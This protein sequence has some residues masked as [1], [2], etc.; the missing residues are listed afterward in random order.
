MM[1]DGNNR[2]IA[3]RI[4]SWI[5]RTVKQGPEKMTGGSGHSGLS[6]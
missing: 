2:Q 4:M 1:L 5:E 6:M 3:D